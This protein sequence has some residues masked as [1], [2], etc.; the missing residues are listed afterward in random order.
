MVPA[1][2]YDI[3]KRPD[4]LAHFRSFSGCLTNWQLALQDWAERHHVAHRE[5]DS[6]QDPEDQLLLRGEIIRLI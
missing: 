3:R 4:M 2:L 5:A 6:N 1:S